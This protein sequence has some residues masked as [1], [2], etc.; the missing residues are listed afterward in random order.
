MSEEQSAREAGLKQ[1]A[2]SGVTM[3]AIRSALQNLVVLG[4][5]VFLARKLSPGD[6]GIFGILHF[7][8]SFFRLVSDTGLGAALV[9]KCEEP[10]PVELSTLWWFQLGLGVLLVALSFCAVPFLRS[11]WPSLPPG[12]EWL[13]PGLTVSLAFSMLQSVPFLIL[14]RNVRFGWVG[15]LEFLGTLAFYGTAVVLA[16]RNAGAAS[17]VWATVGQAAII[18]VMSHFVQPWR[19]KLIFRFAKIRAL[20]HFGSAFQGTQIVGYANGAV[21]PLLVGAWLGKNALGVLQFAQNTAWFPT[22]LVGVVRR[23]YFPYLCRLQASPA[24]FQRE[25]SVAVQISAVPTF[26]FFGL[27]AGTAPALI[28]I[29]YGAKW[30]VSLPALYVYSFG[31]CF[32][33]ISWIG[34]AALTAL[35]DVPKLL[36]ITALATLLNWAAT[37]VATTISTTPFAFSCGF[38]VHLIFS[39]L[40]IY[41]AIRAKL[42]TLEIFSKLRGLV[43]SALALAVLGR[44]A[45]PLIVGWPSLLVWLVL[46]LVSFGSL[47]CILDRDL[48]GMV[49]GRARG[50]L[51]QLRL[52][53]L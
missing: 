45:S 46:A 37:L 2:R 13:L 3:L 14:E 25:F 39:P 32:N 52:K 24:A 27:F 41:A 49:I 30:L 21:T 29:V 20:L 12:S 5:N 33:F 1:N 47:A 16:L 36:R 44:L 11:I 50:W 18:S 22:N 9:Q 23:V 38:L 6:Y 28:G 17:L 8:M 43:L 15:T 42:P 40:A 19:P 35:G 4:A 48:R 53:A 34:D 7:A 31:F 10:D 51:L 26:F